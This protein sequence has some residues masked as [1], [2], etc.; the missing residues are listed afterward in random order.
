METSDY[1][2][3]II[4][5]LRGFYLTQIIVN[6]GRIGLIDSIL[7]K[8]SIEINRLGRKISKSVLLTIFNYFS[9]IGFAKKNKKKYYLTE[10]GRDVLRRYS[11]FYVPHSY[12]NYF[13]NLGQLLKG[14]IKKAKVDRQENI[15][16]SGK[17]HLRYFMH[18]ISYIRTKI[19]PTALID[20]GIGNADFAINLNK[21]Y[22]LHKVYGVDYSRVSVKQASKS[23]KSASLKNK[24]IQ[25]DGSKVDYWASKALKYLKNEKIVITLW[26]LV[27]EI[28]NNSE[29]KIIKF[30]NQIKKNIPNSDLIIC[31]LVDIPW[32]ILSNNRENTF[33]P[34]Y[35]LFHE[36][37]DQGVLSLEKLTKIINKSKYK[38]VNKVFFDDL[39]SKRN[40]LYPSCVLFYLK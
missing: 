2:K 17:T 7:S 13:S 8:N 20:I 4:S 5:N 29:S 9:N 14:S 19:K 37:S 38:L 6:L 22:K 18:A 12:K 15:L 31:E 11:S 32:D 23:M 16:G 39:K 35:L 3:N 21:Y 40:K 33:I 10:L 25:C 28:S 27:H 34:E 1:K 36:L 24:V 30:L 26:F